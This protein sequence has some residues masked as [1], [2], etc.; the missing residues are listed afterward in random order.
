VFVM[1]KPPALSPEDISA[2]I[3]MAL[4]DHTSFGTIECEYGLNDSQVKAVM[5]SN[6]KPS[7][8]RTWRK[9]VRSFGDRREHYK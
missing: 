6:L 9:R 5:R 1:T 2:I 3:E 4:S 8:Y 7:S